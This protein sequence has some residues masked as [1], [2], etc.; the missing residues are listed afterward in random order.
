MKRILIP[1][2]LLILCSCTKADL[3]DM[4]YAEKEGYAAIEW[5]DRVYVPY[6][7][8]D[9]SYMGKQIGITDGDKNDG[10]Y[11]AEGLSPDEWIISYY[12]SGE[13]D[14]PMLMKEESVTDIPE[15]FTS[16]YEW[17]N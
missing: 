15:G 9:K 7:A 12:K 11:E 8:V 13:M 10:V 2:L 1:I 16:E 3:A 5:E 14:N 4:A 6:S 17:N